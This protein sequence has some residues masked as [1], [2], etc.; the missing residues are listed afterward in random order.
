MA[1]AWAVDPCAVRL[2]LAQLPAAAE[3]FAA[4]P[5]VDDVLLSEPQAASESAAVKA[6]PAT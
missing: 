4:P 1:L 3:A 2:P 6:M 5:A